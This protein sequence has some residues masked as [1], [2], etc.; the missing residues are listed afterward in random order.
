MTR[1]SSQGSNPCAHANRMFQLLVQPQALA[2][3]YLKWRE[4]A[5]KWRER[6]KM[7]R[8]LALSVFKKRR[9]LANN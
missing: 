5:Q 9:E 3:D 7:D 6:K 8:H 4:I 1:S 2:V